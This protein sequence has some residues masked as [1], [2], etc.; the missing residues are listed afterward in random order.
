MN[1]KQVKKRIQ[2][3][4]KEIRKHRFL[5]HVLDKP[6]IS[7]AAVDSLKNELSELEKKF[8]SLI[9]PASPTQRVAGKPLKK[10]KKVRHKVKQWSLNDA[11][12]FNDLTNWQERNA[13]ILEKKIGTSFNISQLN[14]LCELKIDGLHIVL[15]YQQGVLKTA[16]TRGDG[17]FGENV[18]QNIKTIESIPLHLPKPIDLVVEGEIWMSKLEFAKVN[19]ERKKEEQFANPRNAAAGSVR[20]LDSK[21]T[22]KRALDSFIY[23]LVWP[24][25]QLPETQ[26]AELKF[27][28]ANG[29]KIEKN[30]KLCQNLDQVFDF[31]RK[32]EKHHEKLPYL[33]DGIVIKINQQKFQEKLGYTGKAP[34]FCL[35]FKF[36]AEETTTIIKD[37]K[38]QVGRLGKLTP[39]AYLKPVKLA[40]S[41]VSRA[42]LHNQSFIN[43][44]DVRVGDTVI[45]RK[46]GD[47]IPEVVKVLKGLR[48]RKSKKFKIKKHCPVCGSFVKTQ[49]Q[50][51]SILHFCTNLQCQA[52][53]EAAIAHFVSKGGFNIQ[54]M[55]DK[56]IQKFLDLGLITDAGDIFT[57]KKGDIE[58]LQGFGAKSADNLIKA[59]KDSKEILLPKFLYA[60]GI[61]HIGE[62]MS[63]ILA[64]WLKA[65][66]LSVNVKNLLKLAQTDQKELQQEI[67]KLQDFGP[68]AACS[69]S[70]W[71]KNKKNQK[72]LKK[73]AKAKIKLRT[74]SLNQQALF[75]KTFV[76]T[77]SLSNLSRDQAKDLVIL[78][79]GQVAGSV[80]KNTD[81]IV[82]GSSPGS[83]YQKAKDLKIKILDQQQFLNLVQD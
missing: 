9:T 67:E 21:I 14:Y 65:K 41:I 61:R 69:V 72:L 76:F 64:N 6:E 31:I 46:A 23:D 63:Q 70:K 2:K 1:K 50:T 25:W 37:V 68:K 34:R 51:D 73:I 19:Q 16:A 3:L 55:G 18:T 66:F 59:I 42:T 79:G 43:E 10:F 33:V 12:D 60:L 47:I 30:F 4:R 77:G 53:T 22:A 44:L 57:L 15:T 29:F 62:R 24:S 80:S 74:K 36:P 11:F 20:Q 52:R 58:I 39:V 45:I 13:K 82:V 48:S 83:K 81:F 17:I 38:V 54:G 49:T 56:I 28:K 27:L 26:F 75:K 8:P 7:D 32:W 40:G 78:K 71:F 5:Y 35:A